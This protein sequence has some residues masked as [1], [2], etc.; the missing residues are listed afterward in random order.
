MRDLSFPS[1]TTERFTDSSID[2]RTFI[3]LSAA[4]A[5]AVMLPGNATSEVTSAKLTDEYQFIVNH[6][7]TEHSIPTLVRFSDTSGLA[8]IDSLIEG[9]TMT[10]MEPEPAAFTLLTASEVERVIELPTAETLSHS[11]GSNP[12]WR[13]GYY[14]LGVFPEPER[15][16]DFID[17]EQMIDGMEHLKANH[18]DRLNF[19]SIG[20]SPG[21]ENAIS[22]RDD[23]KD[24]YVA[25]VTNDIDDEETFESKT[26]ILY[27]L[28][29][30]GAERQGVE[31]GTRF[32]EKILTGR[33][34]E[35]EALLDEAVLIFL[36][37]NP[38]GWVAPHPQYPD[39]PTYKRGNAEVGD[40][41]R[42]FPVTGW[43]NPAHYPAEPDG[44]NLQDDQ[45]GVDPDVPDEVAASVPD[46]LAM[47][48]HLREYENLSYGADFHGAAH[49]RNFVFGLIS[50]DQFSHVDLHALYQMNHAIDRSMSDDLA[51]WTT[52]ADIQ[53]TITGD[54]NVEVIDFG[55][56][57]EEAYD[58]ASIW[59]T[60]KYTDSGFVG[61]WFA[62]PEEL[63]GLGMT[64]MDLEMT[65]SSPV[66]APR[67]VDMW[68]RG[69]QAVVR[70]LAEY[71]V[72]NSDTPNTEN[73]FDAS[74]ETA[75]N[76]TA[77]VTTDALTRSSTDLS[78][79][80]D[81]R[82]GTTQRTTTRR[83]ATLYPD[84]PTHVEFT[85]PEATHSQV[86]EIHPDADSIDRIAIRR[87]AGKE[88]VQFQADDHHIETGEW[89]LR[90]PEP[91]PLV[92]RL[93]GDVQRPTDVELKVTTL[94]STGEHPDP[95]EAIGFEQRGYKVSP[96]TFFDKEF[97]P[98][99]EL[100]H[101]ERETDY[102]DV[103]D[104]PVDAISRKKV[105]PGF[106]KK[107]D[108]LVIIHDEGIDD[109]QYIAA[110]DE[111]VA[112]GGNLVL[113][114][115]GVKLL[116]EM[117]NELAAPFSQSDFRRNATFYVAHIQDRLESHPLLEGSRPIQQQLWKPTPLGYATG[118]TGNRPHE[119]AGVVT[120]P[121]DASEAPMTLVSNEAFTAANGDV[122][123]WTD[124]AVSAGTLRHKDSS[125]TIRDLIEGDTGTIHVIG[126]L[127][128][129]ATQANLHPFGLLDYSHSFLG[130]TMLTNALGY[131]QKRSVAGEVVQEIG[132]EAEFDAS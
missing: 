46:A 34:P 76:S 43:I 131:V 69:F 20:K 129:P 116:A 33:E 63:G 82:N 44:A 40:T 6:T 103:T 83:Q 29:I 86:L 104:A 39:Q 52:A 62:H 73:E 80:E 11:P 37:P 21:F 1:D 90:A 10:T 66:Y 85:V 67:L 38:D 121:V 117:E 105:N 119:S 65:Y 5:G 18:P 14:P 45:S 77:V 71:A 101:F 107:Y 8:A 27:S 22:G 127:F 84:V 28:S 97:L 30:H 75:G 12:F 35:T 109:D 95:S 122:A 50:Q 41:N 9:E 55:V 118:S 132:G 74:V 32:I 113:T 42:Q 48:E 56:L 53:E 3:K 68:V 24:V 51:E 23:S 102:N 13:L 87:P 16:L 125:G 92:A 123:G 79:V 81:E 59:D 4:T 17:Y 126:G 31:A 70:G 15:S 78:F 89:I 57:P 61:D 54:E 2:R 99:D 115:T 7:P 124:G 64:T 96:F 49:S 100:H 98:A 112:A 25:E 114:D 72:Q 128:P 106:S 19:Y 26:K 93:E 130:H 108:N 94:Q 88:I 58:W 47:V 60:V 91:G 110:L 36:Y 120:G 111:F